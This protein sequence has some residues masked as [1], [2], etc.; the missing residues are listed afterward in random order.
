MSK[1]LQRRLGAAGDFS[2]GETT[3][4]ALAVAAGDLG[5]VFER[6]FRRYGL[7]H[8]RY[9]VLRILRGAGEAGLP[10]AA[11]GERLLMPSPDVTRLIDRLVE[12]DWVERNRAET[13]RR[14]VLHRL[15][16]AGRS[17]LDSMED[18]LAEIHGSLIEVLGEARARRLAGDCE[19]VIV[20]IGE[21]KLRLPGSAEAARKE[22]DDG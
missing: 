11:I 3:A 17:L 8:T 12:S 13:D 20:A 19:A 5:S 6:L 10:Q 18:P 1:V 16:A 22:S 2:L 14:V 15:T 7:T 4:L 21:G 9:N